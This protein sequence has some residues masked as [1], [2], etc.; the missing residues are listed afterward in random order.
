MFANTK[1]FLRDKTF[2]VN[3]LLNTKKLT[4][5]LKSEITVDK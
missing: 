3:T 1:L 5:K 2:F 4:T